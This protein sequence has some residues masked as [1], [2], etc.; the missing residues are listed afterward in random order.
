MGYYINPK[1]MSKEEWLRKHAILQTNGDPGVLFRTIRPDQHMVCM[2]DNGGFTAAGIA[3]NQG[4]YNAFNYPND[5]RTKT[6]FVVQDKKLIEVC[7]G[8]ERALASYSGDNG[9]PRDI[10]QDDDAAE[11]EDEDNDDGSFGLDALGAVLVEEGLSAMSDSEAVESSS[12]A[13]SGEGGDFGGGGAS[14]DF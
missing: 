13:F 12:E 10:I 5:E 7:P 8:V 1:D 11:D 6:W 3:Y 14:G 4:E 9:A 2:V